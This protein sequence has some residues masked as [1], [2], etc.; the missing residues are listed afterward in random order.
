MNKDYAQLTK[1][2]DEKIPRDCVSERAGGSGRKLSYL[3]GWYVIDRLNKVFGQGNWAYDSTVSLL[4]VGTAETRN[5]TVH[6]VHYSAKVRLVVTIG[7][8][9]TEFSD[10]G[11][12]DG[13]DSNSPGKAHEL[14]I[15]ESVTDG[16]K[17]C[18]K[19][20]GMSFGLALY[21]KTQ[22]NVEEAGPTTISNTSKPVSVP[23]QPQPSFI[24]RPQSSA[25]KTDTGIDGKVQ[26]LATKT[27]VTKIGHL[28]RIVA[29]RKLASIDTMKAKLE[30]FG[31][32]S[33]EEL[34]LTQAVEMVNYLNT[35]LGGEQNARQ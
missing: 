27:Y 7:S 25:S 18:A 15:K 8:T 29:D 6:S 14:A 20:L 22:E 24:E 3:E 9:P 2:M 12:G 26:I 17:R 32:A 34:S 30:S 4:H 11:Y 1:E 23:K 19:N 35:L 5:G 10:Y 16:L 28:S 33:K 21:D 13:T 31:V